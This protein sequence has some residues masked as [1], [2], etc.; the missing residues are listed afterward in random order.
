MTMRRTGRPF[1]DERGGVQVG[2]PQVGRSAPWTLMCCSH[3]SDVVFVS[4][5]FGVGC[6]VPVEVSE[7]AG[8]PHF[9]LD[10]VLGRDEAFGLHLAVHL[11]DGGVHGGAHDGLHGARTCSSARARPCR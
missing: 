9:E 2:L 4:L 11:L 1:G 6:D 3:R 5:N 10:E 8:E 7:D